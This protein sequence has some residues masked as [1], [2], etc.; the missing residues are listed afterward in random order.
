[1]KSKLTYLTYVL[2][3]L[4]IANVNYATAN[5]ESN[6]EEFKKWIGT[7]KC[8]DSTANLTHGHEATF[9]NQEDQEELDI[10]DSENFVQKQC[11]RSKT[12]V[13]EIE[14]RKTSQF[15]FWGGNLVVKNFRTLED[16]GEMQ[17]QEAIK[18]TPNRAFVGGGRDR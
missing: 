2:V 12:S 15:L 14:A 8:Q 18:R 9:I 11:S 16:I 10:V 4:S 7:I 1:M 5:A 13:L 17:H 6:S 3:I